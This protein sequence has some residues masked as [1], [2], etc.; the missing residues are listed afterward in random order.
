MALPLFATLALPLLALAERPHLSATRVSDPP[1]LDGKLDDPAWSAAVATDAFTQKFPDEGKAPSE[2]TT[3]RIVYDDEAVYVGFDCE[4]IHSPLAPRLTRRGRLVESDWVS[5][6][7]G[8]RS[9]GKTADEFLVNASGVRVDGLRFNDTEK[10]DDRDQNWDAAT[11]T[12]PHGWSAEIKIPLHI[13]RFG[14]GGELSWDLEA[15]RHVSARQE[16]DEWAFFPR[17]AAGEVSHYGKLEGL[18]GLTSKTP[19]ELRP[20]VLGQVERRDPSSELVASGTNWTA[21]AGLDLKWHPAA[22]LTLDL[23]LNPD[24]AQVEADQLVLNLSNFETYFP[25]KRPF[26]FEGTDIFATPIQLL[27]TRRIGRAPGSPYLREDEKLVARPGARA[28]YGASKLTGRIADGWSIGTLQA[29]TGRS[30]VEVD[31]TDRPREKR[32]AEP[33]SAY[34][35]L[36]LKRDVG[37]NGYVGFMGTAT[38]YA[39]STGSYPLMTTDGMPAMQLCPNA[40]EPTS[41]VRSLYPSSQSGPFAQVRPHSRCFNNAFTG[42]FDWRWRSLGGAWVSSGQ[43]VLSTLQSGADRHVPDGTVIHPGDVGTGAVV[44][45]NKEGGEHWLGGVGGEYQS[46][47]FDINDLGFQGRANS[48]AWHGEL[49]YRQLEPWS[50]FLESHTK[51]ELSGRKNL[52]G[53]DLGS[54]YQLS[55]GGLTTGFWHFWNGIFYRP[56]Y[57]DDREVGNGTALERAGNVGYD[58]WLETDRAQP[59]GFEIGATTQLLARGLIFNTDITFLLRP[60]PALE[61][62]LSPSASYTYG[63]PRFV[64]VGTAP[65]EYLFGKLTAKS[66]SAT[67]RATYTF[68]PRLTLQAYAQLLSASGH[69][70][71]FSSVTGGAA[72]RPVVH[73]ADLVPGARVTENPDFL[74]GAL[75]VNVVLRWEYRLGSIAYLVYTRAQSPEV[76]LA[77]TDVANVSFRSVGRGPAVDVLLLKISYWWG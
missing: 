18:R 59:V 54:F 41:P 63:E 52:D 37:Q 67:L 43:A 21:S 20:F 77:P 30:E 9:D 28:I 14:G 56:R 5:I 4:Q 55:G 53:L 58:M 34:H 11:A 44:S 10:T 25:E 72:A 39:E 40:R 47:T 73:L 50:L 57:F 46:R 7:L 62:G 48:Y 68:T 42:G 64:G 16:T 35:V 51:V 2:R 31:I 23:T 13:L 70:S 69:Y 38:T 6:A 75:N 15:R 60:V 22:D 17:S 49:E 76:N 19:L 8:T 29:I 26:F 24:F 61:L 32:L 36:R 71:D 3:L 27:Y 12:T 45:L 1:L 74:D 65:G 66:L 33:L